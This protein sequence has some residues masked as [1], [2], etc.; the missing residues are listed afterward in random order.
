[1]IICYVITE[2]I[3][4][5]DKPGKNRVYRLISVPYVIPILNKSEIS[6]FARCDM[7]ALRQT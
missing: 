3:C 1:M 7:F 5:T 6:S 2:R 4:K